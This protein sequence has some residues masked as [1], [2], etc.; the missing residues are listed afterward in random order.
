MAD[1]KPKKTP[2]EDTKPKVFDVAKPSD[3]AA[4]PTSRPIIVSH[5]KS[6]QRDPM[7]AT[8][9]NAEAKVDVNEVPEENK[10]E[11]PK[12]ELKL[13]PDAPGQEA[14]GT[15]PAPE[16]TPK[17]E[18]KP[19]EKTAID[20]Q[21]PSDSAAVDAL[22]DT[23]S[24]KREEE[25]AL[26]AE[27]KKLEEI[28]K[29]IASKQYFVKVKTAPGKRNMQ[30][31]A[32]LVLLLAAGAAWYLLLGP[33][34][35]LWAGA[36]D[37]PAPVAAEV[38]A[39]TPTASPAP[40]VP[41]TNE[42]KSIA[43]GV[44]MTYPK[45]WKVA[46]GK[47]SARVGVETVTLTS[48]EQKMKLATEGGE[49]EVG[50][51]LRTTLYVLNTTSA[52]KYPSSEVGLKLCKTEEVKIGTASYNLA[53]LSDAGATNPK[54]MLLTSGT[55]SR[56]KPFIIDDQFQ[57]ETK[58]NTYSLTVEYILSDAFLKKTGVTDASEIALSQKE[59]IE[60]SEANFKASAAYKDVQNTIQSLK[61]AQ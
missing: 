12:R 39:P 57:F 21:L 8:D 58:K 37:D 14:E 42:Y 10:L 59:G 27:A 53:F 15:E 33:G 51:Y 46:V 16:E 1:G 17:E 30:W 47:D 31:L 60:V 35:D 11:K 43:Q 34:K 38:A 20:D 19:E 22:A 23:V 2:P 24:I 7:M 56:T 44:A 50:A 40:V 18:E 6:L 25:A 55:C 13:E 52:T 26:E 49:S 36:E 54:K 32:L 48:D 9:E 28:E 4:E 5:G 3:V 29:V 41:Q 45:S 61:T